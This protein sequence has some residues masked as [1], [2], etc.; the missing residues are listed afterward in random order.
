MTPRDLPHLFRLTLDR[1]PALVLGGM[2]AKGTL[3]RPVV[4]GELRRVK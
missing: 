1:T 3:P 4:R 2:L